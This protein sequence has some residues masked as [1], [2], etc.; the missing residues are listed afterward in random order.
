MIGNNYLGLKKDEQEVKSPNLTDQSRRKEA[1]TFLK[2]FIPNH[3]L[4]IFKKK[5]L[6]GILK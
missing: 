5:K 1:A 6:F 3:D 4:L 2:L